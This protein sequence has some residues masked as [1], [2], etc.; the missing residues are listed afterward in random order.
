MSKNKAKGTAW[1]TAIVRFLQEHGWHHAE[2]RALHGQ[3]DK[4]DVTGLPG[5][6]IEAKS[7]ARHELA[8]WLDE[9]KAEKRN[10]GAA[11]CAVWFKRRGKTSPGA[12]FVLLDG[13]EYVALLKAAGW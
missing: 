8:A 7:A 2:R 13:D 3:L 4:G 5:I 10:A 6:C 11:T 9:A 12:G 1:E